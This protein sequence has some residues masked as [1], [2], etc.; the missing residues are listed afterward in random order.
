MFRDQ[1]KDPLWHGGKFVGEYAAYCDACATA[2]IEPH[3]IDTY[4]KL[5]MDYLVGVHKSLH[6]EYTRAARACHANPV[7][8]ECMPCALGLYRESKRIPH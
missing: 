1:R 7:T 5:M 3:P 4:Y 8:R 6:P 2:G